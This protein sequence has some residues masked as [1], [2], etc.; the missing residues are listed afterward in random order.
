MPI[1]LIA[2]AFYGGV[3]G[4][5]F[6]VPALKLAPW[7]ILITAIKLYFGG[8]SNSSERVMHSKVVMITVR[9]LTPAY[10]EHYSPR[11]GRN[12]WRRRIHS[13]KPR[14]PRRSNHPPHPRP[15][16]RSLLSRLYR[17]PPHQLQESVNIRRTSRSL[18]S[19]LHPPVCYE[20]DRQRPPT[21]TRY[22]HTLCL[23]PGA[24]VHRPA[25][26][27]DRGRP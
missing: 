14:N 2:E 5:P 21:K 16:Y 27:D 7:I 23:D 22:G 12:I 26:H 25:H 18:L 1:P 24:T 8:T 3:D 6:L 15:S 20:M 13:P 10:V 17:R 11:V 4:I 19:P 9:P